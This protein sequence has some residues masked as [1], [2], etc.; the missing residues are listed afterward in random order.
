MKAKDVQP[1]N[2]QN[3]TMIHELTP[4][5]SGNFSIAKGTWQ[6]DK[7]VRFAMRWD[8]D[9][10]NHNDK[11]YPTVFGKPMWFQL[12]EDIT[13]ILNKLSEK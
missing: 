7:T 2:F 5:P 12:P 13:D 10:G 8:G 9:R 1:G 6:E 4:S 3:I 11:G